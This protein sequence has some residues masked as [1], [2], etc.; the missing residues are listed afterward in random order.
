VALEAECRKVP[1]WEE[2]PYTPV[3]LRK[4]AVLIDSKRLALHSL[5]KERREEQKSA[6]PPY[7]TIL[8]E[9]QKERLTELAIRN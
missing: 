4:S 6:W 1:F 9:Y 5:L 8:H 2:Y 3:F 7:P